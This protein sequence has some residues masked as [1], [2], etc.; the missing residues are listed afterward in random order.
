MRIHSL[1]LCLGQHRATVAVVAALL[2]SALILYWQTTGM[3]ALAGH[4]GTDDAYI[5]FRYAKHLAEGHGLVY[6]PGERVEG[7]SNLLY[8]I[9]LAGAVKLASDLWIYEVSLWINILAALVL[10]GFIGR[11]RRVPLGPRVAAMLLTGITPAL[12]YWTISGL[13]AVPVAAV[14]VGIILLTDEIRRGGA[15]ARQIAGLAAL[16]VIS[17]LLRADGFLVPLL[18]FVYLALHHTRAALA[19]GL[20]TT[21]AIAAK[22][23]WRLWYYGVPLPNTY[24]AKVTGALSDRLYSSM[25]LFSDL[26]WQTGLYFPLAVLGAGML[27]QLWGHRGRFWAISFQYWFVVSWLGYWIYVGGDVYEERFLLPLFPLAWISLC[28]F[29]HW[30]LRS[31]ALPQ[32]ALQAGL[33]AVL[34]GIV[35]L[36]PR[37]TLYEIRA[38]RNTVGWGLLGHMLKHQAP[39][40]VLA[41]DAAGK[42]PFVSG[43]R[44]IDM[45]GLNDKHIARL[46]VEKGKFVPGHSKSDLDYV[47]DQ[48]PEFIAAWLVLDDFIDHSFDPDRIYLMGKSL[49]E[50]EEYGYVLHKIFN[51]RAFDL[52]AP[53]TNEAEWLLARLMNCDYALLKREDVLAASA[54]H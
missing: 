10:M 11:C 41:I 35:V 23:S 20:I 33:I 25:S 40:A 31:V 12:A 32:R 34:A 39:D 54:A 52:I 29:I 19:A 51:A 24:Y 22:F 27:V 37:W 26:V 44:T 5:S 30:S 47:L 38:Q 2:T 21:A 50:F 1:T 4:M 6:N 8:V 3:A 18:C 43:L 42:A 16:C 36:T 28:Y 9:L 53:P 15:Q 46:P 49:T 48:R 7:Y 13:E 14:Q 17:V 45:Y